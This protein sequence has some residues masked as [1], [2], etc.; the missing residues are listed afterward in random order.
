MTSNTKNPFDFTDTTDLPEALAKKLTTTSDR[1]TAARQYADVLVAGRDAGYAALNI[2]Q[3]M[4]AATRLGMEV[5]TAQTV[6]A[7]LDAGV[8]LGYIVKPTRQTYAVP[9]KN[10]RAKAEEAGLGADDP[11]ATADPEEVNTDPLAGL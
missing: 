1:S 3:I 8:K 5:P 4:A 6:R 9:S 10:V 11:I 2:N 7:Y